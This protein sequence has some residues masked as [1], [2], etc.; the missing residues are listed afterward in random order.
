MAFW[1]ERELIDA[2]TASAIE[3]LYVPSQ[4]HFSQVLLS[5]GALLIGLG[6]LSFVAAN[7]DDIPKLARVIMILVGYVGS[8]LSAWRLEAFQPRLS[9]ACLLL[10]SCVYGAGIFLL[11]Q[12]FH[13]G[14]HWSGAVLWWLTGLLPTLF[15]F[16]D[17]LQLL[18]SQGLAL[19]Y[20]NGHYFGVEALDGALFWAHAEPLSWKAILTGFVSPVWPLLMLAALWCAW[21]RL[22]EGRAPGFA[23]NM[24]LTLNYVFIHALRCSQSLIAASLAMVCLG[25]FLALFARG[26]RGESLVGWGVCLCGVF[27]LF[28]ATPWVWEEPALQTL[29]PFDVAARWLFS[30]GFEPTNTFPVLLSLAICLLLLRL[31]AQ[32]SSLSVVFFCL[33]VLYYYFNSFYAF[34]PKALAFSMGGALLVLAGLWVQRV[35]RSRRDK[36]DSLEGGKHE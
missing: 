7:W 13:E 27:G 23:A 19:L 31:I 18:L 14:G 12:M 6:I 22:E 3:G 30:L 34:M 15:L 11:A 16:N 33:F 1:Q 5:L 17:A 26:S 24:F 10:G 9:R 2:P 4:G 29:C 36:K 35:R 20:V 21:Y 8:L 28:L 32:G 25:A